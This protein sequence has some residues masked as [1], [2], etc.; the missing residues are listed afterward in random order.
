MK[1]QIRNKAGKFCTFGE[2]AK[3]E[4]HA[5]VDIYKNPRKAA[6]NLELER[7]SLRELRQ[8]AE[9]ITALDLPKNKNMYNSGIKINGD[10]TWSG[11]Y[12]FPGDGIRDAEKRLKEIEQ[13][14]AI[15][16]TESYIVDR[17]C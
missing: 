4:P 12:G 8:I 3:E 7:Q 17:K 13:L 5:A 14:A 15:W 1:I 11:R 16:T 6:E 10:G 2:L 9:I